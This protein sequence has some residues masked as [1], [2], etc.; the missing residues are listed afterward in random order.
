ML[1]SS[2]VKS[3]V[4]VITA[5]PGQT[6]SR[7]LS[8]QHKIK[9]RHLAA[10]N[11]GLG[12][13]GGGIRTRDLRVMHTSYDFHRRSTRAVCGLDFLFTL[14]RTVRGLPSSLYTFPI[15]GLAR[16]YHATGFPEF[17]K[18]SHASFLSHAAHKYFRRYKRPG[19]AHSTNQTKIKSEPD[20]LPLLHPAMYTHQTHYN[21][22]C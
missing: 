3:T 1:K 19:T 9:G 17:D 15:K 13:S 16:D 10:Q 12:S 18:N 21:T 7:L 20:E 8:V 14:G 5:F 11:A 2:F 22:S 6:D 4:T